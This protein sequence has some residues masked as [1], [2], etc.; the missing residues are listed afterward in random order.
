M[1]NT[2][3]LVQQPSKLKVTTD[4]QRKELHMS[5]W[6]RN[7]L[8]HQ[9]LEEIGAEKMLLICD[10]N[11]EVSQAKFQV[12]HFNMNHLLEGLSRDLDNCATFIKTKLMARE[13]KVFSAVTLPTIDKYSRVLANCLLT[14]VQCSKEHLPLASSWYSSIEKLRSKLLDAEPA[15]TEPSTEIKKLISEILSNCLQE[16]GTN[17]DRKNFTIMRALI[18]ETFD[19]EI[20]KWKEPAVVTQHIAAIQYALRAIG[21]WQIQEKSSEQQKKLLKHFETETENNAFDA[22]CSTMALAAK[23]AES[24]PKFPTVSFDIDENRLPSRTK[25]RVGSEIIDIST[26]FRNGYVNLISK[27]SNLLNIDIAKGYKMEELLPQMMNDGSL[28][29]SYGQNIWKANPKLSDHPQPL[30]ELLLHQV[31]RTR[32]EEELNEHNLPLM[33]WLGN[34]DKFVE[35]LL[36]AIHISSGAPARASELASYLL[37]TTDLGDRSLYIQNG[38]VCIFQT[39]HKA[40]KFDLKEKNLARFLPP[41]LSELLVKYLIYIRPIQG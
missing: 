6:L 7:C 37:S 17:I 3:G 23:F 27:M 29:E 36:G 25:L 11:D 18:F 1:R 9:I 40:M 8:W 19:S 31:W 28:P 34:C 21:A 35:L 12:L 2:F 5:N 14:L 38:T 15:Q 13:G 16:T 24:Q 39:Y 30:M 10:K 4:P 41:D 33:K 22:L 32:G 26:D 20:Q